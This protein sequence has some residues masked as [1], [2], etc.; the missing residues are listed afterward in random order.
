MNTHNNTTQEE[1]NPEFMQLDVLVIYN[2][3]N[4]KTAHIRTR[5]SRCEGLGHTLM[6]G[7]EWVRLEIYES[8][9]Q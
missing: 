3:H 8:V 1:Q 5:A 2:N 7:L 4:H 9:D 6:S